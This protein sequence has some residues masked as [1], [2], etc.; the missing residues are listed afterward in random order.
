MSLGIGV[1]LTHLPVIGGGGGYAGTLI[2]TYGASVVWPLVNMTSGTSI[3]S[4]PAGYAG[5]ATGFDLQNTPGPIPSEGSAPYLDGVNDDGQLYSAALASLFDGS[6]GAFSAWLKVTNVGVWSDSTV[7]SVVDFS[8]GAVNNWMHIRKSS[9]AG[10]LQFIFRGNNV[11]VSVS[12]AG[13][14][15][16]GWFQVA[17]RWDNP[18]NVMQAVINGAQVG[19]DQDP[20]AWAA[21]L[22]S[23]YALIGA[24]STAEVGIVNHWSGYMAYAALWTGTAPSVA[25]FAAMYAEV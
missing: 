13:L 6:V 7:R 25:D 24:Q 5:A 9:S 2:N 1:G 18:N 4:N 19:T 10:T 16:T 20:T 22:A 15:Y 3:L 21:G 12:P 8:S 11:A 14:S 17:M 23:D